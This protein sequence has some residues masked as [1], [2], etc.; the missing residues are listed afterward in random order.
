MALATFGTMT[1]FA[2][3]PAT[4]VGG[5]TG[6]EVLLYPISTTTGINATPVL[7]LSDAQPDSQESFGRAITVMPFNG[8]AILVVA[9][10]NEIF[11]YVRLTPLYDDLRP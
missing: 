7:T 3:Y 2:G 8:K 9:A 10:N 6:G 5:V 11:A 4:A 1:V